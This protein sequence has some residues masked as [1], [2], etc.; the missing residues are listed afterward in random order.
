[1]VRSIFANFISHFPLPCGWTSL[2]WSAKNG[3]VNT[4]EVLKAAGARPTIEAIE[5]WTPDSVSVFHHNDPSSMSRE[6]VESSSA[7]AVESI[8]DERQVIPGI[9]QN[10]CYCSGCLLVSFHLNNLLNFFV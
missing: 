4:T 6:N 1:M 3:S 2:H 8:G 9:W 7:V 10:G 5:G